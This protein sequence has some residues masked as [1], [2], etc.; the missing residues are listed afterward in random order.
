MTGLLDHCPPGRSSGISQ[1]STARDEAEE[2]AVIDGDVNKFPEPEL[3]APVNYVLKG[4]GAGL[5]SVSVDTDAGLSIQLPGSRSSSPDP[6]ALSPILKL[7]NTLRDALV[8][9]QKDNRNTYIPLDKQRELITKASVLEILSTI[10][11]LPNGD[12]PRSFL[13]Q[14][15]PVD[16]G[17][18]PGATRNSPPS[19]RKIFTILTML[20]TPEMIFSFI[21]QGIWDSDLPFPRMFKSEAWE[22]SDHSGSDEPPEVTRFKNDIKDPRARDLFE[23]YQWY[24]LSPVF[25]MSGPDLMH[26]PLY[27]KTPLPFIP[28]DQARARGGFGEVRKVNIHPAHNSSTAKDARYAV[29]TLKSGCKREFEREVEALKRFRNHDDPHL[30]KLLA[31]YHDGDQFNLIFPWANG[32]LQDYWQQNPKPEQCYQRSRWIAEQCFGIAEA[33]RK[34]HYHDFSGASDHRSETQAMKGRHGDIKPE[35]ILWFSSS[36]DKPEDPNH[37]REVLALSDFGLTR[38]HNAATAYRK[39]YSLQAISGTYRAPEYD[40]KGEISPKWDIWTLG[41]VFLE[42]LIWYLQ[43]WDAV[44]KFSKQRESCDLAVYGQ[45]D[46][47]F[48]N[49]ERPRFGAYRKSP[50]IQRIEE[51]HN[52][53][54]CTDFIHDFLDLI[55]RGMI[56]IRSHK[57]MDSANIS[58]QMREMLEKCRNNH[59]YC[60]EPKP[61][62]LKRLTNES[63]KKASIFKGILKLVCFTRSGNG[64]AS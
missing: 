41:C 17:S 64:D 36:D 25:D 48:S 6:I 37:G 29:K 1:C 34:I 3:L 10:G 39:K 38:F 55:S 4:V 28:D 59:G 54:G 42:F 61:N 9:N 46:K 63:D 7:G 5:D 14:I 33:L 51:L 52:H 13:E 40:L 57:R 15:L 32:N 35:N 16:F 23:K 58:Q 18:N 49:E 2:L 53:S 11:M 22:S 8:E 56:R 12:D 26:Y 31:T 60:T 43:G 27:R 50:V 44:D 21:R 24:L 62:I 30:V 47:F 45:E 19:R 20:G